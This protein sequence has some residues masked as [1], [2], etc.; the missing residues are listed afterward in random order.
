VEAAPVRS[1]LGRFVENG[2]GF[3]FQGLAFLDAKLKDWGDKVQRARHDLADGLAPRMESYMKQHA[4]WRDRSGAARRGLKA[5]VVHRDRE[6]QSDVIIGHSVFYG[7]FLENK[8][9]RGTSYAILAPTLR[10]F[11]G[12]IGGEIRTLTSGA[13]R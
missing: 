6:G 5:L 2:V 11:S 12:Q 13:L 7:A 4:A 8:T 1:D 10:Y 9:Y 3:E